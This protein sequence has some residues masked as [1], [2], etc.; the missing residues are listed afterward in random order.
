VKPTKTWEIGDLVKWVSGA[1]G[2]YTEKRG[3][4]V[5]IV[6]AGVAPPHF[7]SLCKRYNAT[8]AYGGG[9]KRSHESYIVLVSDFC[10]R[11]PKLYW[12]RA[13]SLKPEAKEEILRDDPSTRK[14]IP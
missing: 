12:P 1:G 2:S 11:K 3:E 9:G 14:V 4:I 13:S 8:N 5:A 6:P 7:P 10:G